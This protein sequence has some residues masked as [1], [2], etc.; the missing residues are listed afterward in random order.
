MGFVFVNLSAYIASSSLSQNV[1]PFSISDSSLIPSQ[2][3]RLPM[4]SKEGDSSAYVAI[5]TNGNFTIDSALNV[6]S[7]PS[8]HLTLNGWYR[9]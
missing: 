9:I 4:I 1:N 3:F 2:E 6:G 5:Q 7:N 8:F